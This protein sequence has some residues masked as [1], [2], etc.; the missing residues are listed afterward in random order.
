M[1]K[2]KMVEVYESVKGEGTQAGMPMVFV[3]FS[4]C[5]LDCGF[6]DTPYNRIA[7]ELNQTA[8]LAAIMQYDPTWVIFTGGEPCLQLDRELTQELVKCGISMAIETNGMVWT[9]A[10]YDITYINISP[11][12]PQNPYSQQLI[13]ACN[14]GKIA[15]DE[16]R[17][18]ITNAQDDLYDT[19]IKSTWTSFSP[20]MHDPL[21]QIENW[22]SGMGHPGMHG[23]VDQAAFNRCIYLIKRYKHGNSR[24]SVQV[25]KFVGVR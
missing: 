5:N 18:I 15:V 20:L 8:L 1:K 14:E 12:G 11:K 19:G 25:H 9:E 13:D 6:C 7:I 3:R 23:V 10:L 4:H 2:Y 17:F 24:L 22:K 21:P 16:Q